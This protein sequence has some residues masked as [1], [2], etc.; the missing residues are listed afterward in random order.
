[1]LKTNIE[2]RKY[3]LLTLSIKGNI[4]NILNIYLF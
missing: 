4:S 2:A 1:M 3:F